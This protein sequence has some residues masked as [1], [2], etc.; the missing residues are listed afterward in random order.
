MRTAGANWASYYHVVAVPPV[1]LLFGAG[2]SQTGKPQWKRAILPGITAALLICGGLLFLGHRGIS[3][4][5]GV[6]QDLLLSQPRMIELSVLVVLAVLVTVLCVNLGRS[7]ISVFT[8]CL[9]YFLLSFQMLLGSWAAFSRPSA[10][11]DAAML[12]KSS[13]PPGVLIVASGGICVDAGGHRVASDAPNMYYWLD[14]KGFSTC[15]EHQSIAEL[16][17]YKNRGA[18]YYVAERESLLAQPGFEAELRKSFTL[19]A[20]N[21]TALLFKLD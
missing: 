21:Q 20:G 9:T 14:R 4:V 7:S 3:R 10:K 2:I 19:V 15:Q 16:E 18:Q 12:L 13:I 1:A 11:Y 6:L 17:A 5:P 8:G